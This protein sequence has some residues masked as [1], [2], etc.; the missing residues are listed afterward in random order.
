MNKQA[1]YLVV[2]TVWLEVLEISFPSMFFQ[3]IVF[4]YHV[5]FGFKLIC[6]H[7]NQQAFHLIIVPVQSKAMEISFAR[8]L[9]SIPCTL[10]CITSCFGSYVPRLTYPFSLF[11]NSYPFHLRL[12]CP[13]TSLLPVYTSK[14]EIK[15]I[16]SPLR[17]ALLYAL[18]TYCLV[19]ITPMLFILVFLYRHVFI[20]YLH[21]SCLL[22]LP[23]YGYSISASH[24][25]FSLLTFPCHTY[26]PLIHGYDSYL[27]LMSIWI[28][29]AIVHVPTW[30]HY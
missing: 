10:K 14:W 6:V 15:G 1:F 20:T 12:I 23:S 11:A 29:I 2:M 26:L 18:L 21:S 24:A 5:M 28:S 4:G 9:D 16:M 27:S 17:E 8:Y 7:M 22:L 25:F 30:V 3:S 19:C 13:Y